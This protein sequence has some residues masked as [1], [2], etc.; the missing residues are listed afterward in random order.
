LLTACLLLALQGPARH[1]LAD[2]LMVAA[3]YATANHKAALQ[4]IQKWHAG[5]ISAA[6]SELRRQGRRLRAV[7]SSPD[8]IDFHAVEAA[9]LMHAEAGLIALQALH[10]TEARV[11]LDTSLTLQQ[12]SRTAAAEARNWATMRRD[13]FPDR[14]KTP[15][16]V[17][18]R[19]RID[20]RDFYVALAGAALAIGFPQTAQPFAETA[21][22]IAP[23]D[24]EAQLVLGC[25]A[26]SLA[27]EELL[28]HHEAA[29]AHWR[30]EAERALRDALALEGGLLEA[31]LHLGKL[32]LDHGRLV[33]AEPLFEEVE[34]G[35]AD[36]RQRYLA[37]LFLG[38]IA[39]RLDH[40]DD[41]AGF[42][43]R[44]AEAW[45]DSQA[46]RLGLAHALEKS[47][48]PAAARLPVAATL[49]WSQRLDRS[50]DPW[51]VYPWGPPGLAK[52][53][54]DRLWKEALDR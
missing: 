27:G 15:G 43:R 26:E 28:R 31:R 1:D 44:A 41:A 45:P 13:A 52:A 46:A 30:D 12:W 32:H 23:L 51:W 21:R 24:P 49:E 19:E 7:P 37:L 47:S 25:A 29:A 34:A 14:G 54:V 38:R 39:E 18:I 6:V 16:M 48:G 40:P 53:A 20:R 22:Q 33:E 35:T 11:H 5:A 10:M 9:V 50:V 3:T 17:E 2:Y 42:Y 36:A 8:D 4:E